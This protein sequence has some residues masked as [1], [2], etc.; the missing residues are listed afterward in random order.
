MRL[1]LSKILQLVALIAHAE[2]AVK[3]GASKKAKVIELGKTALTGVGVVNPASEAKV[4][5][6]IDLTVEIANG[7]NS[8]DGT[9]TP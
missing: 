1:D 3:S 4:S 5:Q 7:I 6:W 2:G 8:G 9:G